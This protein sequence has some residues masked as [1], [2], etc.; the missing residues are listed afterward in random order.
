MECSG[1]KVWGLGLRFYIAS[2]LLGRKVPVTFATGLMQAC[3]MFFCS[4][5]ASRL[6]LSTFFHASDPCT[7]SSS[8]RILDSSICR[9]YIPA[10]K[11]DSG[12][13]RI[14]SIPP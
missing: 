6:F 1:L 2:A 9:T 12:T 10:Q 11:N 4:P 3:A 14:D 7:S 5:L 8:T 13:F